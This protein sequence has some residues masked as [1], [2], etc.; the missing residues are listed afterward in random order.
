MTYSIVARDAAS[1]E[2]GVAV[3]SHWFSVGTVV[4]W[5]RAGV[6]AV[7]TQSNVDISYGPLGLELMAAGKSAPDALESLLRSDPQRDTRQVAMIDHK[8]R[9]G[10][11]TGSECGPYAGHV[12]SD[13]FSCQANLMRSKKVWTAM[14][15]TFRSKSNSQKGRK[16]SNFA[17]RLVDTL[18][19]AERAGGDIRGKQSAAILVVSPLIA[20]NYWSGRRI[21]LR[22]EDHSEPLPELRRLLRLHRTYEWANKGDEL[23]AIGNFRNASQAYSRASK[24][25]PE[26]EELQFWQAISLV[27][28]GKHG[29][30]EPIFRRVFKKNKDWIK[31]ARNLPAIRSLPKAEADRL[32]REESAVS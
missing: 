13:N 7:A 19:A 22:V 14:A 12:F 23:A 27:N 21:D 29:E 11:H 6:G 16:T 31:L 3:Q 20:A 24:Y 4:P 5:A 9:I 17:E 8:G 30:A 25:A 32:L 2:L 15:K 26:F 18:F 28:L 10:V 1:G